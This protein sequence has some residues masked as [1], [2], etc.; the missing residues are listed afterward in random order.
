MKA[1]ENMR[2]RAFV[3]VK[4]DGV[5]RGLAGEIISRF[6]RK[7]LK[8][9]G[10]KMIHITQD[11]ASRQYACHKGRPFYDSLVKFMTSGPSMALVLEGNN[12][13]TLVRKIMGETGPL[14]ST[15]GTIRGDFAVDIQ[16]NLVHGSDSPESMAHEMPIYFS[17][18]ELFD[19]EPCF[20][21]WLYHS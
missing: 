20:S 11:Q 19:Y 16:F 1:A 6:E 9:V 2:E 7:G 18:A 13:I 4:P 15:P 8:I 10:L 14:Q 12:A 3:I 21:H 5:Q 17:P